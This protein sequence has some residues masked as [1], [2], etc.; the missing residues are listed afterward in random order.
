MKRSCSALWGHGFRAGRLLPLA[1]V[2]L[3]LA[4]AA[5]AQLP[6]P[7]ARLGLSAAPD[8]HEP[9]LQIQ[10]GDPFTLY[11][12]AT[13]NEGAPLPYSVSAFEWAVYAVCC[14]GAGEI[15]DVQYNPAL[16]HEGHPFIGVMSTAPG[17]LED[18]VLSLAAVTFVL[19]IDRPGSYL[20]HAGAIGPT[21][22]CAGEGHLM[23]DLTVEVQVQ[24]ST[25]TSHTRNW[26]S[27][28]ASYR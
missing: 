27:L 7:N 14:G 9:I 16:S 20:I 21:R 25:T 12:I 24:G 19:D 1:A 5:T 3:L 11:M 8:R 2:L 17:C 10:L 6:P 18:G 4:G 13:G 28:K 26:G 22:D 15:I 23:M